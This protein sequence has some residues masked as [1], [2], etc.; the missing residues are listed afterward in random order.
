MLKLFQMEE[1]MKLPIYQVDAFT[2]KIFSGNPAAICPLNKW[3]NEELMKNIARENNLSETA[4]FVEKKDYFELRWFTPETEVD[5]CGHATLAAS[6]IILNH[7]KPNQNIIKFK[8]KSGNL[9][10]TKEKNGLISMLFPARKGER[11]K[12]P[13][14]L[15]KALDK[16]PEQTY[17]ARDYML[18]YK[19][20]KIIKNI[21][22]D[23]K[24]LETVDIFGTIIT[25]PGE[26]SDF[27][28]RYFA[29]KEG[30]P[31]DPVTG[32]AHCT[33]VPYWS[34]KLN[35]NILYA[36]QLSKRGGEIFCE[37]LDKNIKI[38]G[39]AVTYSKGSIYIDM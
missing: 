12:P 39:K 31:E 18:V 32:S 23:F 35:K 22:P 6:Y 27:V 5:L 20:E 7:L 36:R 38:S 16:K 4:F 26:N 33:L 3:I 13:E 24:L 14:N 34:K 28:S 21:K 10:V 8:T 15:V 30:I 29:P 9:K 19:N 17:L 1:Q 2:E 25:A 11:T 37:N